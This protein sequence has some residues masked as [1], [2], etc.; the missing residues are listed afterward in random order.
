[1]SKLYGHIGVIIKT[2]I[3]P[4]WPYSFDLLKDQSLHFN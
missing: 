2:R 3:M 1:M 4:I